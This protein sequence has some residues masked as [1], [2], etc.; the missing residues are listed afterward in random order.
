MKQPKP[1]PP[2]GRRLSLK[3]KKRFGRRVYRILE[4]VV[5]K[6]T[7]LKSLA[8]ASGWSL[9]TVAKMSVGRPVSTHVLA[10]L[11]TALGLPKWRG[12]PAAPKPRQRRKRV[13]TPRQPNS[14]REGARQ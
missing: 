10:D 3:G 1:R 11:E 2:Y 14:A 13:L 5:D 12:R 6:K 9:N 7:T 4:S 8:I